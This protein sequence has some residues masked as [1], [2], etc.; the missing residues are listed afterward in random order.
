VVSSYSCARRDPSHDEECDDGRYDTESGDVVR[1]P[2]N[3][4]VFEAGEFVRPGGAAQFF[5][6]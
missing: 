3:R 6:L 4:S 2:A 1:R 5:G